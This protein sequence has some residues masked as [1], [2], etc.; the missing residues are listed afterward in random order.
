LELYTPYTPFSSD[1]FNN[2]HMWSKLAGECKTSTCA[3]RDFSSGFPY[4]SL[5]PD[6]LYNGNSCGSTDGGQWS[7]NRML[8]LLD[9]CELVCRCESLW[10]V[11]C[12]CG[13]F[14]IV[15]DRSGSSWGRC[16]VV[17]CRCMSLWVVVGSLW[18]HCGSLQVLVTTMYV[19]YTVMCVFV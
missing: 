6:F 10:L 12:R 5:R 13:W 14:W 8:L 16:W 3:C 1:L 15:V 19:S 4:A 18:G 9:C 2:Q 11:V 7:G 17:V